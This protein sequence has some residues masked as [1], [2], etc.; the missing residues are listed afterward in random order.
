VLFTYE[1]ARRLKGK[2][3]TANCLHPGTIRTNIWSHAGAVSPFTRFASLFMKSAKEGAQTSIY[4][5][6][7]PEV[8][9]VSGKY[10]DNSKPVPSSPESYDEAVASKLWELSEKIT[11]LGE[12]VTTTT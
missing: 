9:G 5:A 2:P 10:F 4:L 1:L 8:E 3:V 6:S 7:S 11:H 12:S